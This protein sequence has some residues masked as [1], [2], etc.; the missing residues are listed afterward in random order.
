MNL[1][2]KSSTWDYLQNATWQVVNHHNGTGKA[3]R[4]KDAN[5]HGKTGTAQNPHGEDHSWFA[6]YLVNDD[7][8]ILSLSVLVEHGGKGSVEAALIS[9]AI[10]KYAKK[11]I[12]F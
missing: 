2:L 3:A 8:P 12:P 5:V 11:N 10:F 9:H 6:G 7:N 4:I 1:L